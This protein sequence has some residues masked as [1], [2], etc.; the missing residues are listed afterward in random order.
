MIRVEF[1]NHRT[2]VFFGDK[3]KLNKPKQ[4]QT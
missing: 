3:P 2:I 1:V 4:Q